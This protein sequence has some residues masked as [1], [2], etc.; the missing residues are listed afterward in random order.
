MTEDNIRNK[1]H[2]VQ[3]LIA[4]Y[5]LRFRRNSKSIH[6]LA[7]SK[8]QPLEKIRDLYELGHRNFGE[9]YFQELEKKIKEISLD[10]IKWHFI[11]HLQS[12]KIKKIV[13]HCEA[14]HTV[15]SYRHADIIARAAAD[16]QKVPF[17]VYIEVNISKST[18]KSGC[19]PEEAVKLANRLVSIPELDVRGFMAIPSKLGSSDKITELPN[20][21][22]Q[23]K[24]LS[25]TLDFPELSLGMSQ[26]LAY[27]IEAGS[28]VVRIGTALF[29][30]RTEKNKAP[31]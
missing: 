15:S 18:Q 10:Q 2:K 8:G 5:A 4:E 29:G 17:K 27:A 7:V 11:G 30:P 13:R 23:L 19:L 14:I 9:N 20:E 24:S 1:Y 22:K 28:T 6:L 26:D 12:N 16:I 21:Y 31:T 25:D 3:N